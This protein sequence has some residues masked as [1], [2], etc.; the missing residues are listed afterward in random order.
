MK[1][2]LINVRPSVDQ[3]KFVYELI[4]HGSVMH[5][6][7]ITLIKRSIFL[8]SRLWRLIFYAIMNSYVVRP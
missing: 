1:G 2:Y 7:K 4:T 6:N 5:S 3:V 8:T